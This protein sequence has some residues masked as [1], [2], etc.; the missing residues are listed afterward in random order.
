MPD[1]ETR[2]D[3]ARNVAPIAH[4]E[5]ITL[6]CPKHGEFAAE[7][8]TF[9]DGPRDLHA[10]PPLCGSRCLTTPLARKPH[11]GGITAAAAGPRIVG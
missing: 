8:H 4:V 1:D 10:L 9:P 3:P 7:R 6:L 5:C 2:D 11:A